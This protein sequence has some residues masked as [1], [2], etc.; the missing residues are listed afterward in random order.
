MPYCVEKEY[1]HRI[2]RSNN[3]FLFLNLLRGFQRGEQMTCLSVFI[4]LRVHRFGA[5]DTKE[6]NISLA[7]EELEK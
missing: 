3:Y 5:I 2:V 4:S 6:N 1:A 7:F